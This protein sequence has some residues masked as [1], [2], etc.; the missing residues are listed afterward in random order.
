[1]TCLQLGKQLL[2]AIRSLC[3]L[4]NQAA[5]KGQGA[6]CAPVGVVVLVQEESL[7]ALPH[8]LLPSCASCNLGLRYVRSGTSL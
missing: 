8:T 4:Q 7:C 6:K 2:W 1:M 5:G 3:R